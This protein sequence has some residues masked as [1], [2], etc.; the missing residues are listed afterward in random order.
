MVIDGR[1]CQRCC[2]VKLVLLGRGN[3]LIS[4]RAIPGEDVRECVEWSVERRRRNA[5]G[6]TS[7]EGRRAT[8]DACGKS[9]L[10]SNKETHCIGMDQTGRVLVVDILMVIATILLT[11]CYC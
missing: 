1:C 11:Q 9:Q 10:H 8:M 3:P 4:K 6:G 7:V 2:H 5:R